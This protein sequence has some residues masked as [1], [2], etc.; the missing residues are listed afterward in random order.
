MDSKLNR[1][2][3]GNGPAA[4]NQQASTTEDPPLPQDQ[5]VRH[6]NTR[7]SDTVE[8]RSDCMKHHNSPSQLVA[9]SSQL[10]PEQELSNLDQHGSQPSCGD[11]AFAASSQMAGDSSALQ[12]LGRPPSQQ[13]RGSTMAAAEPLGACSHPDCPWTGSSHKA[14]KRHAHGSKGLHPRDPKHPDCKC[15]TFVPAVTA[16][17]QPALSSLQ[18]TLALLPH[19]QHASVHEHLQGE[20]YRRADIRGRTYEA[21]F[22]LPI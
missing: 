22:C 14:W 3:G 20:F 4:D 13:D 12:Q 7:S 15:C 18:A 2:S 16:T 1:V 21:F 8:H 5:P 10:F 9:P 19:F 11:Q 6:S 17:T